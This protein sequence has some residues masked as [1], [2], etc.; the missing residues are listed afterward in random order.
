MDNR[1]K[2][3]SPNE[4]NFLLNEYKIRGR[5]PLYINFM[6]Y[7]FLIPYAYKNNITEFFDR[8]TVFQDKE[9]LNYLEHNTEFVQ[10]NKECF[11]NQ[12]SFIVPYKLR[13]EKEDVIWDHIK[14]QVLNQYQKHVKDYIKAY[15]EIVRQT[16]SSQN[17][18]PPHQTKQLRPKPQTN[19]PQSTEQQQS[20]KN[21][22]PIIKKTPSTNKKNMLT[23]SAELVANIAC[24]VAASPLA[25]AYKFFDKNARIVRSP[26]H[27]KW[28]ENKSVL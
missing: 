9:Y 7:R 21:P 19:K 17:Q 12:I 1:E 28:I 26:Q 4:E 15:I 23:K 25:L 24:G 20:K 8:L 18:N 27:R 16:Q 22:R 13:T 6:G 14:K 3:I 5:Q 2:I 10:L 11:G